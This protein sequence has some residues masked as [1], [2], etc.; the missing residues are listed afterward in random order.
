VLVAAF[1]SFMAF[2]EAAPAV[3]PQPFPLRS[4]DDRLR[5][6]EVAWSALDLQ[7]FNEVM[8]TIALD[9][10]CVDAV[11]TPTSASRYHLLQG[12]RQYAAGDE[13]RAVLAFAAAR[14]ADPRATVPTTL[15]PQGH[16]IHELFASLPID[17][18][19]TD[20]LPTPRR[21]QL[22]LDG[23]EHSSRPSEWPTL[24]QI[25]GEH[26]ETIYLLPDDATPIYPSVRPPIAALPF[27][28]STPQLVFLSTWIG[29]AIGSGVLYAVATRSAAS[30]EQDHPS[31]NRSD[32]EAQR[33][34]TN[35]LVAVSAITGGVGATCVVL[36]AVSGRW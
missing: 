8:D 22:F 1:L 5:E 4:L 28:H 29:A 11:V 21:V 25:S 20:R 30:F 6:A 13:R 17:G 12:L 32:L 33:G 2:A 18:A 10:P 7:H 34:R 14:W 36:G 27:I 19:D 16:V 9:L 15:V 3:C 24:F 23:T 31:W 26:V 35:T